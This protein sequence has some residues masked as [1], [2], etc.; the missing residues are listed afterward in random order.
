[1]TFGYFWSDIKSDSNIAIS[2]N[3]PK[4]LFD[5]LSIYVWSI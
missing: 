5:K 4:D 1:M 2:G 3:I